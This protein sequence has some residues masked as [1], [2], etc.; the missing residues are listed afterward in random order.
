MQK[1][2]F[3]V[4]ELSYNETIPIHKWKRQNALSFASKILHSELIS[5]RERNI[6]LENSHIVF[7]IGRSV[8]DKNDL[9]LIKNCRKI[10][11]SN[12][13]NKSNCGRRAYLKKMSSGTIGNQYF[14]T[15]IYSNRYIRRHSAYYRNK[16][17]KKIISINIDPNAPIFSY[18]DYYIVDDYKRYF[19]N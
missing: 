14:S 4:N 2:V 7:G 16:K 6:T 19:I 3:T 1:N 10:Q 18:S 17:R 8:K 11:C 5:H 9:K 13:R 15:S 12:C